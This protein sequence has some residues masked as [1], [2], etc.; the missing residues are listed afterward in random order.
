MW[1][2]YPPNFDSSKK[3]PLL[4][5]VHGGPHN[6]IPTDFHFRWNLQLLAAQ[7]YVVACPNFHG[8]SGFGQKFTDS[9][10][11]DMATKPFIDVMRATD[12]MEQL[13]YIDK[14]RMAAAGASY[15]GYMM[16][17]LNGHTDRFKAMICHAGVYNWHSMMASDVV[18]ARARALGVPPWG[19]LEQID[20]QTPQ[21]L[22]GKLQDAD[23]RHSRRERFSRP[24]DARPRVFQHVASERRANAAGLFPRRESLGPQAAKC[25]TV[26]ERGFRLVG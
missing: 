20:K 26:D 1:L 24:G 2:V 16:S 21:P 3:W 22:R 15:G 18:R 9:I 14:N 25:A 13:A 8:S 6:A 12:Y 23:T 10:T 17:W 19:D 7:G 11:G 5:V 4:M